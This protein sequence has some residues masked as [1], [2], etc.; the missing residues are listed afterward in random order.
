MGKG[1]QMHFNEK[2][3]ETA[4]RINE[5]IGQYLPEE[6]GPHR[7]LLEAVNYSMLAGGKRLRPMM[8][9]LTC[10]QFGGNEAFA[11]PFMAA[12]EMI[13]THSLIHDDLPAMDNDEYRRGRKTTHIV[14]GE[15]MAILAG[16]ALLNMAYETALRGADRYF[17]TL[18][19]PDEKADAMRRAWS[20]LRILSECTGTEG[21][22]GGQ[23]VDVQ[24]EG[25]SLSREQLD[26][27]YRCK[28]GA[29][30]RASLMMGAV[31]G[32]AAEDE[33]E[34]LSLVGEKIGM[35]FQIQDDI[36][37][38]TGDAALLGKSTGSDEKN[39]KTTWVTLD[40]LA[41]ASGAVEKYTG[42]AV[43]LLDT[44]PGEKTF[45]REL[46]LSL[47]KRTY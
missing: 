4:S 30:I 20:A 45:L 33:V 29:L 2:L 21:M 10:E 14:F 19:D 40:G 27:I 26:F 46:L 7:T 15:A 5:L 18:S 41:S 34:K 8:I 22:I 43:S 35:A 42:E 23:S 16:D 28:T 36:L 6:A 38:V 11:A 25:Q 32:G 13:H 9:L 17:E 37:D 31:L 39:N 24:T 47:A 1:K 44:L 3:K 12:M